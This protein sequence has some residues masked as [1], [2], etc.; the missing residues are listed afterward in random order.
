MITA[1]KIYSKQNNLIIFA[2]LLCKRELLNL[3]VLK[4]K[5]CSFKAV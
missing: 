5:S 3:N 4:E 1:Q 2:G